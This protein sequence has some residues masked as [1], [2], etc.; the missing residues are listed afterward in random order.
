MNSQNVCATNTTFKCLIPVRNS[1]KFPW[2]R[3]YVSLCNAIKPKGPPYYCH[4][5]L[6]HIFVSNT[7]E[8]IMDFG[9]S[10]QH[11][12]MSTFLRSPYSYSL[13]FPLHVVVGRSKNI[14]CAHEGSVA[15]FRST[16]LLTQC[17]S[18][19]PRDVINYL[20]KTNIIHYKRTLV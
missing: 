13:L 2:E 10:I 3:R 11:L 7:R 8:H 14:L 15:A 1:N 9:K 17:I 6:A 16:A 19:L 5:P 12:S 18:H 20:R 4:R